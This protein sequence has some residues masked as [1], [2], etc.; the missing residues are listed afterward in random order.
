[1]V[2]FYDRTG[3]IRIL[4]RSSWVA[5]PQEFRGRIT[6]LSQFSCSGVA[7]LRGV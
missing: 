4:H 5:T 1:M 2:G 6:H 7:Y 3:I